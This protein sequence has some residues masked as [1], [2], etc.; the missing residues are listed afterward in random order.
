MHVPGSP[1]PHRSSSVH[2]SF[3]ALKDA[4][5]RARHQATIIVD[6]PVSGIAKVQRDNGERN[7]AGAAT[8]NRLD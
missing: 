2:D 7:G 1:D 3:A 5:D 6:P 8:A 4:L